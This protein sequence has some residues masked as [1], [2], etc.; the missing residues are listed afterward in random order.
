MLGQTREQ[1]AGQAMPVLAYHAS[2]LHDEARRSALR[3][4]AW[5]LAIPATFFG[6]L[7]LW[8]LIP[9]TWLAAGILGPGYVATLG[10]YWRA[11]GRPSRRVARSIWGF[12]LAIQAAWL[13][14]VSMMMAANPRGIDMA[15]L[16][17]VGWWFVATLFSVAGVF[18]DPGY[19]RR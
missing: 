10:Y 1:D 8:F 16:L 7:C 13:I 2:D 6:F 15:S 18:L 5:A 9:G 19:P 4:F 12:S 17:I 14:G 3:L 11:I